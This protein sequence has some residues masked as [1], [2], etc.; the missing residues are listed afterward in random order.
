MIGMMET[1]LTTCGCKNWVLD[2]KAYYAANIGDVSLFKGMWNLV[3]TVTR[4]YFKNILEME[5]WLGMQL[6]T[7]ATFNFYYL[8]YAMGKMEAIMFKPS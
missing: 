8:G 1:E 2:A 3:K 6:L 5:L 4:G 7:T